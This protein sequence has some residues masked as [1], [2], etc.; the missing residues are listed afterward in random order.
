MRFSIIQSHTKLFI[1]EKYLIEKAKSMRFSFS[2]C[3]FFLLFSVNIWIF[4][5]FQYIGFGH[6]SLKNWNYLSLAKLSPE[7]P[8]VCSIKTLSYYSLRT[9]FMRKNRKKLQI[10][11]AK[12]FIEKIRVCTE[13]WPDEARKCARWQQ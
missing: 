13:Q 2:E 7:A 8:K 1:S 12:C 3:I 6:L 9:N 5:Y 10:Q 4:E 11:M